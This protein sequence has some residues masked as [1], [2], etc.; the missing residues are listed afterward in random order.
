M[1]GPGIR[2]AVAFSLGKLFLFFVKDRRGAPRP[3]S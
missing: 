2:P 3:A 1:R